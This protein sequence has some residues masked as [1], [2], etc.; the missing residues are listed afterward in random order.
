LPEDFDKKVL[1]LNKDIYGSSGL[2]ESVLYDNTLVV[3]GLLAEGLV[4]S[5]LMFRTKIDPSEIV[6]H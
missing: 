3:W 1:K 6:L 4:K 2:S 5:D